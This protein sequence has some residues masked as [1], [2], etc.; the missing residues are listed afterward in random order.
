MELTG[1]LALLI[2]AAALIFM[3][4]PNL[5]RERMT[6]WRGAHLAHRGLHD[7]SAG[8][9]ENTLPAFEA[10]VR[11][12]YGME[13][14]IQFSSDRQVVV[15]HDDTLRRLTGDGRRVDE[16]ALSELREFRLMGLEGAR[17]PT[18]KEVLKLVDGQTPLLIE[19]KS[20]RHN[21]L[22]C[23]ALMEHLRGYK[24]AY[25]VESFNPL[26][27]FWFRRHAPG[28]VRGQLVCPMRGYRPKAGR[29]SGFFMAGLLLNC[30]GR[31]DFVA[32]DANALRFFSPHFQRAVFHTPMAAWTVRSEELEKLIE[33]RREI[34]IFENI[35]PGITHQE[36]ENAP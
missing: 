19:L 23:Q 16:C 24:G 14:D 12:G 36:G 4:R 21:A 34:S 9:V 25:M 26:I 17:I 22:L 28:L 29:V 3:T 2:A 35:R 13:L 18:L 11:R 5:R 1:W 20:G 10:A 31:P 30:L 6:P 7:L 8:I 32:Y 27:V 33:D 15:F